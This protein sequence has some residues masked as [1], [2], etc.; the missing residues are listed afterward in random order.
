MLK[1]INIRLEPAGAG[2]LKMGGR[3]KVVGFAIT[4]SQCKRSTHF[5]SK[6]TDPTYSIDLTKIEL[7]VLPALRC[8]EMRW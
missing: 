7:N 4:E 5:A 1:K 3:V 2:S 6:T 8:S